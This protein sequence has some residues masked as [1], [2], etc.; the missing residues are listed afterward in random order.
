MANKIQI[1]RGAGAPAY[2]VLDAGEP[3][4]DTTNKALYIGNGTNAYATKIANS[5]AVGAKG[6]TGSQGP[7]GYTGAT[8]SKGSKGYTG[9]T[10][11]TGSVGTKGATGARGNTG[12]TG[13]TGYT[14]ATGSQGSQ[15]SRGDTGPTGY[16]GLTGATG[17][18]GARGV[19]GSVGPT[20]YTGATGYTG[21][22]GSN[23]PTGPTGYTGPT[24]ATGAVGAKGPTGS[25]GPTGYTGAGGPTITPLWE[26]FSQG[27]IN[28]AFTRSLNLSPYSHVLIIFNTRVSGYSGDFVGYYTSCI[29]EVG[30]SSIHYD[31]GE[32]GSYL[33]LRP[34]SVTTSGISFD[35]SYY[36]SSIGG[37]V[38]ASESLMIPVGIYGIKWGA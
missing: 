13:D 8:G 31:N 18:V 6:P 2:G 22:R 35:E 1:K 14:G 38:Y 34:F 32:T 24:G 15:G 7:T 20:G 27:A 4:W 23:G 21:S 3:G 36:A 16:T 11:P 26:N 37:G 28:G 33:D 29:A 17:A 9:A 25:V 30:Q 10:G 12:P 19:T 5:G